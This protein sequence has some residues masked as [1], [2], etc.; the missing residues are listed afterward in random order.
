MVKRLQKLLSDIF[1]AAEKIG[2]VAQYDFSYG[3]MHTS[4]TG[5]AI[6]DT[7]SPESDPAHDWNFTS[8]RT[9]REW[10]VS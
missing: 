2:A 8:S 4:W 5:I 3:S 7:Y 6:L 10:L 9:G 1:I